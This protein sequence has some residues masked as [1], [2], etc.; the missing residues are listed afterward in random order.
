M[1]T[2]LFLWRKMDSG[3][4]RY[5]VFGG[6]RNRSKYYVSIARLKSH[7]GEGWNSIHR[8][9]G[10]FY[11][12]PWRKLFI[13]HHM[14]KIMYDDCRRYVKIN[15]RFMRIIFD[16]T[17]NINQN[18]LLIRRL[19]TRKF[20]SCTMIFILLYKSHCVLDSKCKPLSRY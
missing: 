15:L 7:S 18:L 5:L 9:S 6:K 13:N 3:G 10:F 17:A 4:K 12:L 8:V 16:D 1:E 20:E 2:N 14:V 11:S 19:D